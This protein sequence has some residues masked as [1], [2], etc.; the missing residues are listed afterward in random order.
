MTASEVFEQVLV[1]K[2]SAT[3]RRAALDLLFCKIRRF[4]SKTFDFRE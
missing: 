2:S 4:P 3:V 1:H